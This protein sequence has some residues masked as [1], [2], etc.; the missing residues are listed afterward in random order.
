MIL[1]EPDHLLELCLLHC[2]LLFEECDTGVALSDGLREGLE[3]FLPSSAVLLGGFAIDWT[4]VWNHQR[5]DCAER[6]DWKSKVTSLLTLKSV[7][8]LLVVVSTT[9]DRADTSNW[10][11]SSSLPLPRPWPLHLPLPLAIDTRVS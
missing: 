1:D 8:S 7:K 2:Q 11:G 4:A 5:V 10:T 6:R 9:A 3:F